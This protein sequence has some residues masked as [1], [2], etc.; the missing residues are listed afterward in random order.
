MV[1]VLPLTLP[2]LCR[3]SEDEVRRMLRQKEAKGH[4]IV[5]EMVAALVCGEL[6]NRALFALRRSATCP[7]QISSHLKTC[8]SC[9]SSTR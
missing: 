2:P 8:C 6:A 5:L 3:K 7:T 4:A 9:A 1:L